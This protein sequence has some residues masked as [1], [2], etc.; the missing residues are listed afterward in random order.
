[1]SNTL[2]QKQIHAVII[3]DNKIFRF[4]FSN[5]LKQYEPQKILITE[6]ENGTDLLE[7]VQANRNI[8]DSKL[9]FIDLN[10]PTLT[11]WELLDKLQ[12]YLKHRLGDP[13]IFIISSSIS[14]L[15]QENLR[16]YPFVRG[17]ITKPFTKEYLFNLLDETFSTLSI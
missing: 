8:L 6:Y 2:D 16:N 17:Y 12:P 3:E 10:M 5:M 4:I 14:K 15:D 1:M 9:L 11:G 7:D 13:L